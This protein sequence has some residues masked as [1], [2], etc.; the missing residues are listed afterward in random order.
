MLKEHDRGKCERITPGSIDDLV[1]VAGAMGAS[2]YP[3]GSFGC[4]LWE[5]AERSVREARKD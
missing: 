5:N 4:V 3:K 1:Y 2:L